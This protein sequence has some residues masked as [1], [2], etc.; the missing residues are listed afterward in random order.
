VIRSSRDWM[1]LLGTG[2]A[3]VCAVGLQ[4]ARDTRY[5]RDRQDTQRILYVRSGAA[6]KR[7]TP[8]FNALAADVY[9]I[10]AVQHYG[11]DRLSPPPAAVKYQLLYP[12]LDIATTLDPYFNIAYRFGAIFLS[13]GYPG[14]PGRPDQAIMLLRKALV[15]MPQKWQYY[16]DIGFVYYWHLRDFHAAAEWFGRAALQPK[17]P[18]WLTPLAASMLVQ[19]QDRASARFMWQQIL[20][21]EE[22]WL[23]RSAERALLQLQ[24]LDEIDQLEAVLRRFPPPAGE[25]Y[26]WSALMRRGILLRRPVD[27]TG[28]P[29]DL[30]PDSGRV[31]LSAQS[32][33]FPPPDAIRQLQ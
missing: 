24:A 12:L 8:G 23:R 14:G 26:G 30:D 6:L 5:P 22:P 31:T 4:V 7:L 9:W 11:G 25:R 3:V 17:A 33:L 18:N 15:V 13:E 27:P 1:L 28:T 2:A 32:T 19:G 21:S 10:R 20:R 16:H 29:F